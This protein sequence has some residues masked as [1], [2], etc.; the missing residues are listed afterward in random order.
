MKLYVPSGNPDLNLND[1]GGA[2]VEILRAAAGREAQVGTG[3]LGDLKN[4]VIIE[5]LEIQQ[6]HMLAQVLQIFFG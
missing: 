4:K 1:S 2:A 3:N 5:I 6:V